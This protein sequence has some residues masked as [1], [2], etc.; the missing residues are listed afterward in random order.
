[1]HTYTPPLLDFVD[2]TLSIEERYQSVKSIL[3]EYECI[4]SFTKVNGESRDMHCTLRED[5]MPVANQILKEDIVDIP[6][7]LN[8]IT[9]WCEDIS[10]W[11][12]IRTMNITKVILAPKKWTI[13]LEEAEDGSGDL[14]MPLPEDFLTMQ[15]WKEGDTLNWKD[16]EDGSWTLSKVKSD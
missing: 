16:N 10:A 13:T 1:M 4:V 3:H 15:G 9:V 2:S 7:N 14:V 5:L 11:R 8:I 12:A 6:K